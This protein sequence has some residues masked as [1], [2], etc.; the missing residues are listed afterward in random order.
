MPEHT[1]LVIA[2]HKYR[3]E[4]MVNLLKGSATTQ[5]I[6]DDLHPLALHAK[7]NKRPPTMWGRYQW[8]VY[9]EDDQQIGNAIAYVN[10]NP[11]KEGKPRQ[12]WHWIT[13]YRGL[14]PGWTTY[15]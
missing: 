1:H 8:K 3:V 7:P 13:P 10:E 6:H 14:G 11:L 5:L 15:R 9:L 2:R 12:V 4:Q